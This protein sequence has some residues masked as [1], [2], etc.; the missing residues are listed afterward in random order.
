M[1]G[2]L[3][4]PSTVTNLPRFE[5]P[6]ECSRETTRC[7]TPKWERITPREIVPEKGTG[8][9]AN[10]PAFLAQLPRLE[11]KGKMIDNTARNHSPGARD[12]HP[13]S[14]PKQLVESDQLDLLGIHSQYTQ[15]IWKMHSIRF[16]SSR[17]VLE[18]AASDG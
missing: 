2:E 17:L 4:L 11:P 3:L 16:D 14:T 9:R 6:T 18:T 5:S 13:Q 12:Q 15:V 8:G 7:A 10:S 1:P